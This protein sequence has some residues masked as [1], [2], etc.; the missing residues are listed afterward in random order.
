SVP[1]NF[2][3]KN[4]HPSLCNCC[5]QACQFGLK[6]CSL[7]DTRHL[8]L[9]VSLQTHCNYYYYGP[10]SEIPKVAFAASLGGNGL[11]KTTSGSKD[12][13]YR[14]VLTNIGQ[15]YNPETGVFTAPVRGVYYVR[16]TANAPTEYPM[17]AVMYRN[18]ARIELIAHEQPSGPGSDTASNGAALLLEKGD[19]LKMVLWHETQIWDNSNHHSTFSG[20]LLFPL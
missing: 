1:I 20:F 9:Q 17:S 16:F 19:T 3:L 10:V 2:L 4:C 5:C 11:Q 15:A 13:I 18:N 14:D 6:I 7:C 12:L 8:Q